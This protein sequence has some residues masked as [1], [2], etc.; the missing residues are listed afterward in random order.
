MQLKTIK[1]TESIGVAICGSN[2]SKAQRDILKEFGVEKLVLAFDKEHTSDNDK[3]FYKKKIESL[4]SDL[5][6]DFEV[7][8]LWDNDDLLNYKMSPTDNGKEVFEQ[9][10]EKKVVL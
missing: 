10:W 4:C 1:P 7:S 8:Y 2:I 6:S 5:K 3:T 9:L